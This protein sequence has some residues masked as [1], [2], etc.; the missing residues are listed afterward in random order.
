MPAPEYEVVHSIH[1]TGLCYGYVPQ[2][3]LEQQFAWA[4]FEVTTTLTTQERQ[5]A[6]SRLQDLQ[7]VLYQQAIADF[8][9]GTVKKKLK[10]VVIEAILK[11]VFRNVLR[12]ESTEVLPVIGVVM[13]MAGARATIEEAS[14]AARREFQLR[15]LLDNQQR[16]KRRVV[17]GEVT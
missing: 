15:W 6:L 17:R 1:R 3:E 13:G 9:E 8:V 7:Y 12:L 16:G 5:Q 10:G 4:I 14:T 11:R 2:T